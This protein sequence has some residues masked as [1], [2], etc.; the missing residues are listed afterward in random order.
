MSTILKKIV[1]RTHRNGFDHDKYIHGKTKIS[2]VHII[3]T[4]VL[5]ICQLLDYRKDIIKLLIFVNDN[6]FRYEF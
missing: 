3:R 1:S 5:A 2:S 4:T 6:F